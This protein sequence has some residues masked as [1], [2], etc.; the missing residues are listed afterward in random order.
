MKQEIGPVVLNDICGARGKLLG[1]R[2][3]RS[4]QLRAMAAWAW[5]L[6]ASAT[7]QHFSALYEEFG[8]AEHELRTG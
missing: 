1:P 7:N 2:Q 3:G 6:A 4:G 8:R 5:A